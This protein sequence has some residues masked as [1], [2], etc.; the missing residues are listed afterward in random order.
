[1][2]GEATVTTPLPSARSAAPAGAT[3]FAVR[4]VRA[5]LPD[6]IVDDATVVAE[7]GVVT[8]I[9]ERGPAPPG[10]LDGRGALCLP[11]V[12]DTHSDG[13]EKEIR[14][15]PG[16]PF[17]VDF[18]L[19]S[20]E[21]RVRAAGVTTIFHG[22]AFEHNEDETRTVEQAGDLC[23]QIGARGG[24]GPL[25][26]HRVLHRLDARDPAGLDALRRRLAVTPADP[27]PLVSFEDHTPGQGQYADT[28]YFRA[29]LERSQGMTSAEADARIDEL[30]AAR[31]ERLSQRDAAIAWLAERA[32][33]GVV[34]LLAHDPANGEEVAQAVDWGVAIAEFPTSV[35]AA[36]AARAAG[37]AVVMGAPNVLRG[38]SHS[39]NVSAEEVV[40]RGLCT[41]LA[42]DYLPST[43]LAGAIRLAGR[44]TVPLWDAVALVTSGPADAAGLVDR[45]RLAPGQR[46]DLVVATIDGAWPTVRAVVRAADAMPDRPP[47]TPDAIR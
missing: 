22:V 12:V 14:P 23:D 39:G 32:R 27:P 8:S 18:A 37:L 41:A 34:R 42:S 20:F 5:V 25:V 21:G 43:L 24:A 1:M 36:A 17:P 13:L 47:L 15:R 35:D 9:A 28:A 3:T 4:H 6:R 45:G 29:Y 30:R 11:G 2:S 33:S 16:V 31:D 38:G 7:D 40:A 44:G 19:A 10:A 46:A 26:D